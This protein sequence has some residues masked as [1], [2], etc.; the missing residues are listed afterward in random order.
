MF[1]W[2]AALAIMKSCGKGIAAF[3]VGLYDVVCGSLRA[4]IWLVVCV[5]LVFELAYTAH[6]R[7]EALAALTT[8]M[9]V[10]DKL[11]AAA[12]QAQAEGKAA[13]A[14]YD[15]KTADADAALAAQ[16]EQADEDAK[17]A[18]AAIAD[19]KRQLRDAW[20]VCAVSTPGQT[21][22]D[23]G[24]DQTA[25]EQRSVAVGRVLAAGG[26]WDADYDRL[27]AEYTDYRNLTQS[28]F[29]D[30]GVTAP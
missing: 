4:A 6:Q 23:S 27:Y 8:A 21:T 24:S 10:I 12:A 25:L 14:E 2:S 30:Q 15:D 18:A 20:R 9:Q 17:S 1:T 5:V 11:S 28:C 7:K 16:K 29:A 13:R 19:G 22:T 26:G 3:F